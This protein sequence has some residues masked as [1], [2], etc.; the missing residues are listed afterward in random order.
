[1]HVYLAIDVGTAG[2]RHVAAWLE[3]G[4]IMTREIY[5]FPNGAKMKN[6]RLCWD[7]AALEAH[8]VAGLKAAHTQGFTPVSIGIDAWASDFV[9]L[10]AAGQ[11]LGDTVACRDD[12]THGMDA[13]LEESL[14]LVFHYGLCGVAQRPSNTVYQMMALLREHPEYAETAED[15][16]LIPE[17]LAYALT[18][19]K[20]HEWTGISASALCNAATG[21]WSE[22]ILT[23]A[24]L[25]E[26]WFRTPIR[27]PGRLLGRFRPEIAAETGF[28]ALVLL[29]STHD[30]GSASMAI[31]A[32]KRGCCFPLHWHPAPFGH[33]ASHAGAVLRRAGGRLQQRG[34]LRAFHPLPQAHCRTGVLP[35]CPPGDEHPDRQKL[36]RHPP[37]WRRH[38]GRNAEPAGR[39]CDRPALIRRPCPKRRPGQP[40]RTDDRRRRIWRSGRLPCSAAGE[41]CDPNVLAERIML[42]R[43]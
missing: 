41:L 23:A 16:L 37:P 20:A 5:R 1:M 40:R 2:G 15:F 14:P 18:G 3:D 26:K 19:V 6:G 35:R 33:R 36:H 38:R 29:V 30:A 10:D 8:V 27:Q 21:T 24:G 13:L 43:L 39:Q 17:Y 7:I 25:P 28:D 12:Y 9:L 4:R 32:P 34:R 11:L 42:S 31:P 22:T